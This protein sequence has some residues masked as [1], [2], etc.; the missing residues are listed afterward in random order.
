MAG[1]LK[2]E[3]NERKRA[4]NLRKHGLDFADAAELFAGLPLV[5]P[6]TREE[7]G[8]ERSIAIGQIRGRTV[9][10]AFVELG[11]QKVR[12]ISLRKATRREAQ[13]YYARFA[14]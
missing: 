3:W 9:V 5:L 8:E 4:A 12:I 2:L 13:L 11:A 7:Y 10:A 1:S 14:H 6:D